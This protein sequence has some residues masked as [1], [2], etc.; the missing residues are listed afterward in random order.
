MSK[1][2]RIKELDCWGK[3]IYRVIEWSP[4]QGAWIVSL[5]CIDY[6][7]LRDAKNKLES[8]NSAQKKEIR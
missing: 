2:Y 6:D 7:N 8:L 3:T 4:S 5:P 1:E